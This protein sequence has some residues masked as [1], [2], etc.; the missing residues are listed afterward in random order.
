MKKKMALFLSLLLVACNGEKKE[1]EK[2]KEVKVVEEKNIEAKE[3]KN[4]EIKNIST[5]TGGNPSIDITM[6]EEIKEENLEGYIKVNP[7]VKYKAL[8]MREHIIITGD[9][10]INSEYEIELLK[11]LKGEKSKLAENK[12]ETI[13]FKEVEP[14]IIFS[15][16]GIILPKLNE[17]RITFKSVNVKRVNLKIKK[18]FLNNTTQFLQDFKFQGD[19]NI[20]DY[21]VQNNFY[22]VGET[23]FEKDYTLDYK[24]NVWSQNEIELKNLANEKGIYIVELSFD[25]DGVDYTFPNSVAQWQR[26]NFFDTKG[27]IGKGILISDMGIVAQKESN[28]KLIVN[29]LDVI[30]NTPLKD[31]DI[32]AISVNNQILEEKKTD[33]NGEVVFE[34]GDKTWRYYKYWSYS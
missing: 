22:K 34:K 5:T 28:N 33:K 2:Q 10:D 15:N 11:G 9:F 3:E 6:S 18:I 29:I 23:I 1:I 21:Y 7:K 8:K 12:N 24:K 31:V 27:R 25:K 16:E 20:F 13:K 17:N 26:D 32:K 4:L 30:K 14:K 19:G